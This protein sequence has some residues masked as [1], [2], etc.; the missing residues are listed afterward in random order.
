[1]LYI[2]YS[3]KSKLFSVCVLLEN[4]F[5]RWLGTSEIIILINY[6]LF[7]IDCTLFPDLF[8][9]VHR[10]WSLRPWPMVIFVWGSLG[11]VPPCLVNDI[12][13]GARNRRSHAS[14]TLYQPTTVAS[15]GVRCTIQ[16]NCDS[17][18]APSV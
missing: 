6:S 12:E 2:Q 17:V 13:G 16:N 18:C 14:T 15:E 10:A 8:H 1:M 11:T 5:R 7:E 3:V 4:Q 9:S